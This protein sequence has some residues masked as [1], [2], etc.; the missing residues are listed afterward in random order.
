M[1]YLLELKEID[2]VDNEKNI[3]RMGGKS[4]L[5]QEIEWPMNP[6]GEKLTLIFSL[7][8]NILN[9]QLKVKYTKDMVFSVFTTYNPDD[10]FLDSIVYH[11]DKEELAHIQKGFTKV[12][13]H[14]IGSPR[15]ES[16]FLIPARKIELGKE[17]HEINEYY[18][19]LFGTEPSFLQ[20][21]KLELESYQFCM[22]VYGGDF[23]E[24]YEDIFCL[25]DAIGYLFLAK[26]E[27]QDDD[28]VFFVQCT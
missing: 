23:P 24:E 19:S 3:L 1:S 13:L 4:F 17:I 26:K 18:G 10:Y 9:E 14:S 25:D 15:N 12:I 2:K 20:N 21:E 16:D 11:G 8:T 6:N 22:Q 7:P 5:P 27:N 28:G